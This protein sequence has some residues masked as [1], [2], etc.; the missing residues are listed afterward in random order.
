METF[1]SFVVFIVFNVALLFGTLSYKGLENL[2]WVLFI[3]WRI[4]CVYVSG[5]FRCLYN[6]AES[7]FIM[8]VHLH[9]TTQ[10]HGM[11]FDEI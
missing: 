1:S 4:L 10:L 9:G 3:V 8:S 7:N 5:V 11:D 6:L 2:P